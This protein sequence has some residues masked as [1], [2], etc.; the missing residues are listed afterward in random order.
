M[1]D[2]QGD[3]GLDRIANCVNV[4][5]TGVSRQIFWKQNERNIIKCV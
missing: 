5:A 1:I 2:S 3:V 4:S